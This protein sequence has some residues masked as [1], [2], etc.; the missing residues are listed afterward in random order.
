VI[1]L[2][3]LVV[4]CLLQLQKVSLS[5]GNI[6]DIT[7]VERVE[8]GYVILSEKGSLDGIKGQEGSD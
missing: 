8:G 1:S 6:H 7:G 5:G 4:E 2:I 3:G